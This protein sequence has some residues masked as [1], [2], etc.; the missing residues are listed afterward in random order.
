MIDT[1]K[2]TGHDNWE[3]TKVNMTNEA[4][5]RLIADAPLLLA[6]VKRLREGIEVISKNTEQ[7]YTKYNKNVSIQSIVGALKGLIE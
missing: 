5:V 6:E 7:S 1:D 2:Y 4:N 3:G